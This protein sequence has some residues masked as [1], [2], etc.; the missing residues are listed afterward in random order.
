[1]GNGK[2][3]MGGKWEGEE[4]RGKWEY[5]REGLDDLMRKRERQLLGGAM[6]LRKRGAKG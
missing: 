1:M 3:E 6:S 4:G 2:W 5:Q